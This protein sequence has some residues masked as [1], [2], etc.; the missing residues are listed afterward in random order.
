MRTRI[1]EEDKDFNFFLEKNNLRDR[2]YLV[3]AKHDLLTYVF[4]TEESPKDFIRSRIHSYTLEYAK[5]MN[6]LD[7]SKVYTYLTETCKIENSGFY[8]S[9]EHIVDFIASMEGDVWSDY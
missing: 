2:M 4:I 5:T 6:P 1:E 3:I 9:V 8:C 7:I